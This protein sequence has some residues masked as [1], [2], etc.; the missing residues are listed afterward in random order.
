MSYW[1]PSTA[2]S[3]KASRPK[4]LKDAKALL[5]ELADAPALQARG[6]LGG[7]RRR[8]PIGDAE[9]AD[10]GDMFAPLSDNRIKLVLDLPV[11]SNLFLV[12]APRFHMQ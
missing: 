2:G 3:P 10:Q 5:D 6:G 7:R 8:R 12:I 1:R 9:A 11:V 4:D